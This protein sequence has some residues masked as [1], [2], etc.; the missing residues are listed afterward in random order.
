MSVVD[1]NRQTVYETLVK[2]PTAIT[3]YLTRYCRKACHSRPLSDTNH[4][5]DHTHAHRYSGITEEMLQGVNTTLKDVQKAL[6]ELISSECIL[7]GHSLEND[8]KALKVRCQL[9]HSQSLSSGDLTS[10]VTRMCR[11]VVSHQG[12]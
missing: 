1:S 7:V 8:L 6:L 5:L 10:S 11:V 12:H 4:S 3:D 2:P 9:S